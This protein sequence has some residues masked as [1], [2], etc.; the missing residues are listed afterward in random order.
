ME[1]GR[2]VR[3]KQ[4]GAVCRVKEVALTAIDRGMPEVSLLM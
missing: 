2:G 4:K 3:V 1:E